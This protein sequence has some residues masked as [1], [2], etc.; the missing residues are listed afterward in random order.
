MV[1][2]ECGDAGCQGGGAGGAVFMLSDSL[3]ALDAFAD[4]ALP[5]H[6]FWVMLTYVLGQVLLVV[7]VR[8]QSCRRPSGVRPRRARASG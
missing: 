6:G 7:A 2:G 8:N 1:C 3:I 4:L 5:G